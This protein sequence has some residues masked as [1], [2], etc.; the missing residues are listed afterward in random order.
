MTQHD[1]QGAHKLACQG[2]RAWS[3][4]L[5]YVKMYELDLFPNLRECSI[6]LNKTAQTCV[7]CGRLLQHHTHGQA[8]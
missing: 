1:S 7:E 5:L 2:V 8:S 4:K 3:Q 6:F